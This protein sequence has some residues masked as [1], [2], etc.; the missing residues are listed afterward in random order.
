MFTKRCLGLQELMTRR[1]SFVCNGDG[2]TTACQRC[3]ERS[4]RAIL[5][6][7]MFVITDTLQNLSKFCDI[8]AT[9]DSYIL[10]MFCLYMF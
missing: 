2:N 4:L 3:C 10:V 5:K 1:Q 9:S 6:H 7:H 8:I